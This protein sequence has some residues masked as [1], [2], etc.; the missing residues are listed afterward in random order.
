MA[1]E[2]PPGAVADARRGRERKRVNPV[3]VPVGSCQDPTGD[4]GRVYGAEICAV[5]PREARERE[6]IRGEVV[7][8]GPGR[9]QVLPII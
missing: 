8:G 5:V 2:P 3:G 7:E 4:P 9:Q 6:Q 1:G